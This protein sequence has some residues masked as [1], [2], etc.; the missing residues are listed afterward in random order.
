MSKF[1]S[2]L[3]FYLLDAGIGLLAASASIAFYLLYLEVWSATQEA[4]TYSIVVFLPLPFL[5]LCVLDL[6]DQVSSQE[7]E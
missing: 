7:A 2:S 6:K 3:R 5:A 4:L 1:Q